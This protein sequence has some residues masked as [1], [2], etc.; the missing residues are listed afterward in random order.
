[1]KKI[2]S[3]ILTVLMLAS[4]S[5]CLFACGGDDTTDGEKPDS[6]VAYTVTAVDQDGNPIK[7]V[8][9]TFSP[10]G[11]TEIPFTTDEQGSATYKTDK[12]VTATVTSV[13]A[14][15]EYDKL[16]E[17][18]SFDKDGKLVITVS[19]LAPF[20]ILVID[21][22]DN[23]V[24]GVKVQ[25][26]NDKTCLMAKTTDAEGKGYYDYREGTFRA[27]LSGGLEAL[28]EGYTSENPTQY[29]DFVN[30]VAT[31]KVTKTAE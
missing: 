16:D 25:I 27:Q 3:L 5:L 30:G 20:V 18:Q 28:P 15:Y 6:K 1:M 2:I 13:P 4:M 14:G 23:P 8:K 26:C 17:E 10:K 21:Q 19:E 12:A 7:G 11:G 9:V 31:I 24:P 22:N 29:Y